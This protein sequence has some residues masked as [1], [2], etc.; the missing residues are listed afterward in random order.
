MDIQGHKVLFVS[1]DID[2]HT[3]LQF[4]Q[5]VQKILDMSERHL[6]VDVHNVGYMDSS[7]L[8]ILA[9]A[10]KRLSHISGTVNLVGCKPAIEY[11]LQITQMSAFVR[12]HESMDDT[13]KALFTTAA[14]Q[15]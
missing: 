6:I 1:G 13:I 12:L 14:A 9:F 2:V 15:A 7:G 3:A 11:I 8:G 5:A 10:V 4:K